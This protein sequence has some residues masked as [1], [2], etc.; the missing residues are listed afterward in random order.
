[1]DKEKELNLSAEEGGEETVVEKEEVTAETES[2]E[3]PVGA[4]TPDDAPAEDYSEEVG[5][6]EQK[7]IRVKETK[8]KKAKTGAKPKKGLVFALVIGLVVAVAALA[9]LSLSIFAPKTFDSIFHKDPVS[10][11][12]T[13]MTINGYKISADEYRSYVLPD[14]MQYEAYYSSSVWEANPDLAGMMKDDI[15]SSIIHMYNLLEW[16]KEL[17]FTPDMF[18][19]EEFAEMKASF[20]EANDL[21]DEQKFQDVLVSA[22]RTEEV[23]DLL[24]RESEVIVK[25]QDVIFAEDSE[26]MTVTDQQLIDYYSENSYYAVK[27]ILFLS[28]ADEAADAEKRA[29]AEDVLA[30]I[31]AGA[32]FD[33]LMN[34]YS[35]DP[36]LATLPNGYVAAPGEMYAE[37]ETGAL[38]LAVGEVSEIVPTTAGYHIILRV[39][40]DV[41]MLRELM[42]DA[43]VNARISEKVSKLQQA[44]QVVYAPNYDRI[45]IAAMENPFAERIAELV[46]AANS[47]VSGDNSTNSE[48]AA[49]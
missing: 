39:E 1:M 21:T 32:D 42:L 46:A 33:A 6:V 45:D 48:N 2:D 19:D 7:T 15:E 8:A 26:Y 24:L 17:G 12:K 3:V 10:A 47:S 35:E 34:T 41:D 36:G 20:R 31:L 49:G 14:K 9:V 22:C 29:L 5:V 28:G 43:V 13:V 25:L 23:F 44:Q 16:A 37:F 18:S 27:H 4:D 40:P 38:A 11:N 30:Q